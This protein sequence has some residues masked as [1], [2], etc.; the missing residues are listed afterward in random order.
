MWKRRVDLAWTVLYDPHDPLSP[1]RMFNSSDGSLLLF[2]VSAVD[3][4][5]DKKHR[6][7]IVVC[8][9]SHLREYLCTLY[10]ARCSVI[11]SLTFDDTD[12][13]TQRSS[14]CRC[15]LRCAAIHHRVNRWWRPCVH[16]HCCRSDRK[17]VPTQAEVMHIYQ[18]RPRKDHRGFDLISDALPFGA[19]WY[20]KP[21]DAVEYA[22]F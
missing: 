16:Y 4:A 19:L 2:V 9:F 1:D 17:S 13:Q 18:V 7:H 6:L 14:W 10:G 5:V 8:R 11:E 15:D 20:T 21:D 12:N 3:N 22:K